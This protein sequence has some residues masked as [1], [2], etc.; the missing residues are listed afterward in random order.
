MET[1]CLLLIFLQMSIVLFSSCDSDNRTEWDN[2][3]EQVGRELVK[4]D[5][6]TCYTA[7][8][9]ID[10]GKGIATLDYKPLWFNYNKSWSVDCWTFTNWPYNYSDIKDGSFIIFQIEGYCYANRPT[11]N[12]EIPETIHLYHRIRILEVLNHTQGIED[13]EQ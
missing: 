10:K 11:Y 12:M 2:L 6:D 8:I 7:R 3:K 1:R 4:L 5:N 9:N 13:G